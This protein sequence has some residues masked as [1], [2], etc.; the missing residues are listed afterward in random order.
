MDDRDIFALFRARDE[1][2]I[3]ECERKYGAACRRLMDQIFC[4]ALDTGFCC[5]PHTGS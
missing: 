2:A 1:Q 4:S 5:F 3:A